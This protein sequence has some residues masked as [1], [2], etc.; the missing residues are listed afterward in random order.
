MPF[1]S[2]SLLWSSTLSYNVTGKTRRLL[3]DLLM[4]TRRDAPE[5]ARDQGFQWMTLRKPMPAR[6]GPRVR[7]PVLH[8][9]LVT[10]LLWLSVGPGQ[11]PHP[12]PE[13]G[14]A[15][16]AFTLPD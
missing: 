6:T 10:L 11:A 9:F 4:R 8:L 14:H 15:A 13:V 7:A 16:P 12:A 2:D 3:P 5:R 1:L